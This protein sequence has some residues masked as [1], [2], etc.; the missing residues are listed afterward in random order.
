MCF[1][2]KKRLTASKALAHPWLGEFAIN[3]TAHPS[4]NVDHVSH[5][6]LP[7]APGY[8]TPSSQRHHSP[9]PVLTGA[10]RKGGSDVLDMVLHPHHNAN[11]QGNAISLIITRR[12][13]CTRCKIDQ[14]SANKDRL[15]SPSTHV[16]LP[17]PHIPYTPDNYALTTTNVN[18][19]VSSL[20]L[21]SLITLQKNIAIC[22][23][24]V[25]KSYFSNPALSNQVNVAS[26]TL[27]A[28]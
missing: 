16:N 2:P 21:S 12:N 25:H 28:D 18:S 19:H 23:E 5:S 10:H 4:T 9:S 27:L 26:S 7:P 22:F 15:Y 24:N 1:D 3:P 17:H 6:Q 14:L 8:S 20:N 13:Q 11:I